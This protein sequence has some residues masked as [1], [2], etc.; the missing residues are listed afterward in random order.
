MKFSKGKIRQYAKSIGLVAQFAEDD[1]FASFL[2]VSQKD[3]SDKT[4]TFSIFWDE[5]TT[6]VIASKNED[7][8]SVQRIEVDI[9]S[10][11]ISEWIC[12]HIQKNSSWLK[13]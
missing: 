3:S 9:N 7:M 4:L 12:S 8:E 1:D 2:E 11:N 6:T 13:S 5:D 10:S